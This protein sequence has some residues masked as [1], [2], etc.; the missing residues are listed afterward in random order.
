MGFR[1]RGRLTEVRPATEDDVE[2]LVRWHAD[3]DV[4][5]YWDGKTFTS[6]EMRDRLARPDVDAYVIEAGGRPVG[7]L[8]AWRG[9][10]P[11][12]GGLDM[13]LVPG[14][15][16]RGYGPDA[17]RTLASHLVGQGWTRMTVDPYVWNDRAI[18]AWRK[19]GFETIEERPAD[20]E[21]AAPWLL[22]EWR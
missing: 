6:Q 9:E 14:E 16:N 22:M 19:A 1:V 7:Y 8:Q 4:A 15:R 10:G 18:A 2:L 11:S 21:H 20:D 3:P 17:A 12:D 5:R 13:F